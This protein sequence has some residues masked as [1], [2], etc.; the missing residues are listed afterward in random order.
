MNDQIL[1]AYFFLDIEKPEIKCPPDATYG[2]D[3]GKKYKMVTLPDLVRAQDNSGKAPTIT[4]SIKQK[5]HKFDI[6]H[7]VYE[8]VYTARDE[9]G[10]TAQCTWHLSIKGQSR[11]LATRFPLKTLLT[12][13][14]FFLLKL[15]LIEIVVFENIYDL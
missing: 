10:L 1:H 13:T 9:A 12:L 4:T 6:S 11:I 15:N 14:T 3:V 7:D 2:N 8:V 5:Q